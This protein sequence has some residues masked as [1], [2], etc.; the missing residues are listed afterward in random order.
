MEA[1]RSVARAARDVDRDAVA[2]QPVDRTGQTRRQP[3]DQQHDA[4]GA[5]TRR[6]PRLPL[7]QRASGDGQG[8]DQ[9][10]PVLRV[11]DRR[12]QR[13]E[14]HC[15]IPLR[16]IARDSPVRRAAPPRQRS[17][18]PT[19]RFAMLCPLCAGA[20]YSPRSAWV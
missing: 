8:A 12:N 16:M 13:R 20:D 18:V 5:G 7:D 15:I 4:L 9:S 1:V 14:R 19:G 6:K 11:A 3:L 10:A 17:P 2:P